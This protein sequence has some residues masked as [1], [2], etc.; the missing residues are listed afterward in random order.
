MTNK[1]YILCEIG[2]NHNGSVDL[3]KLLIDKAHSAGAD[4]V[5]FQKR[6]I[7]SVYSKEELDSPR[8]SQWGTT[9]RQQ[10]EGLEL[11]IEQYIELEQYASNK[12][13]DFIVSCWDLI[14]LAAIE[15]AL[16]NLPYHKLASALLTHK[17]FLEALNK[18]R[19][20]II[21][22]TGMSTHEEIDKAMSVLKNV[23]H[24]L[25]CTSTYPTKPEEINLNY[26]RTLQC[27]YPD[28]KIGFSNHYSGFAACFGAVTLGA[29]M[30]E[31]HITH[32]RTA[33]GSDQAAS[34]EHVQELIDGIRAI[35]KMRGDSVKKVY[36]S[37]KPIISKLR[38]VNTL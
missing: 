19:K 4:G 18:T 38:K 12:G 5:K 31:F 34:I 7:D 6:H 22:S 35:E 16:P 36:D 25:A 9:F 27:K 23:S 11:S 30:I 8:Q 15:K 10:K 3:A 1:T 13:L 28:K 26:I 21:V 32:D 37:E 24:I 29:D 33:V 2:I 20:P 17:E 14:S